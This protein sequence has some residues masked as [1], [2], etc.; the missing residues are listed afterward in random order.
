MKRTSLGT[1]VLLLGLLLGTSSSAHADAISITSASV[2]NVQIVPTAGTLVFTTQSFP[3]TLANAVLTDGFDGPSNQ[4]VSPT[5]AQASISLGFASAAADSNF[6]NM[7]FSANSNVMLSGC[8]CSWEA[9]GF[10]SLRKNFM[11][12]GGD[13]NV[14]VNVSGLLT[15]MQ[16]LMTDQFSL[17][18]GST[19]LVGL[20]VFDASDFSTVHSF[21]F[22]SRVAIRPPTN[23]STTEI[24]RQ[25]SELFTLQFNKEYGL[26]I[27]VIANSRAAQSE[28]PEPAS[29]FL[30]VSGLGFAAGFV[31]K[32]RAIRRRKE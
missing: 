5:H 1:C 28:V 22:D 7:S 13:G 8:L 31:R 32:H 10:A 21:S 19:I 30:L 29:V 11:I 2:T 20:R 15:T 16:T 23:S 18:A 24:E 12:V 3:A 6:T 9:E 17:S 27:T 4:S 14:S 26:S 25:L